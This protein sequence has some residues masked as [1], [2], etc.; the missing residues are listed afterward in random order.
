MRACNKTIDM[1]TGS[2]VGCIMYFALPIILGNL[3]QQLYSLTDAVI[4]GRF[5][6]LNALA[7]IGGTGWVRWAILGVCMDCTL[8]FGIVASRRIG[9]GDWNGFKEVLAAGVEFVLAA[10]FLLTLFACLSLDFV[11]ELLHIPENIYEDARLYLWYASVSIP[12]GLIYNMTCA[13]LRAVGN[14]RGP[15]AAV[16]LS[17]L[18]NV[19]LDLYFIVGLRWGVCGAAR[20]TLI[21]QTSAAVFVLFL[22]VR[23]ELFQTTRKNWK[24]NPGILRETAGLWIPMFFNSIAIS[25]GGVIVQRYINSSG[26]IVAAGIDAGEK[27]YCLLETV[28]KAVCSAISVFVGQNLGAM[29]IARIRK[30]MKSMTIFAFFF[31]VWLAFVLTVY[32]DSLIGL[33]LNKNQDPADLEGAYRAA[34]VYLNVQCISVFFMVPMH[35]YRGAVQALGY[36]VYPM[37]A[38]FLQIAARWITVALFVPARGLVGLCLPDGVAALASL[39]VVVIPYFVFM[40]GC[41]K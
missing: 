15:F 33:F 14:S 32:G 26:A 35:F 38:A 28:E 40:R 29:K 16:V 12:I 18:I 21:A 1:T 10:G 13:F 5:V 36:A 31:S 41:K 22:A 23:H 19:S 34:R 20:A 3:F 2:S 8:G 27:I 25:A 39:P 30:G 24:Y 7:A 4:V 11:L 6:N 9:A 17:T 37:I